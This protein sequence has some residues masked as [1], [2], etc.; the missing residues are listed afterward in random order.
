MIP[1]GIDGP[2]RKNPATMMKK[3]TT[4]TPAVGGSERTACAV[5][6]FSFGTDI[7]SISAELAAGEAEAEEEAEEE[8]LPFPSLQ[9]FQVTLQF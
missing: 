6:F 4:A 3:P 2:E 7:L 8:A 9:G 5:T 1:A